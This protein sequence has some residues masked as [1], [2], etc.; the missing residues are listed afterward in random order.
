MMNAPTNNAIAAK[1]RMSGWMKPSW[2][3]ML[4]VIGVDQDDPW[5][6]AHFV[7]GEYPQ[8]DDAIALLEDTADK[9][10]LK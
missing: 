8:T 4:F 5:R 7:S 6:S 1:M 10:G 3:W 9:A 2:S